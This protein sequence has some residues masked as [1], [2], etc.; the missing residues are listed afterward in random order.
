MAVGKTGEWEPN[1]VFLSDDNWEP[2]LFSYRDLHGNLIQSDQGLNN[3]QW[4]T[5]QQDSDP[6]VAQS[7]VMRPGD[8][9]V[10]WWPT[11]NHTEFERRPLPVERGAR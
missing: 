11:S 1:W 2:A 4:F 3:G 8:G 9:C 6:W 7:S 5:L 10:H